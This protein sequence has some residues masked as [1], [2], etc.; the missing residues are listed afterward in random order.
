MS[1]EQYLASL[2]RQNLQ[3]VDYLQRL[4]RYIRRWDVDPPPDDLVR[5][6]P[7][8][9]FPP[10]TIADPA[11]FDYARG[12]EFAWRPDW[13]ADPPPYDFARGRSVGWRLPDWVVD[14]APEDYWRWRD[15]HWRWRSP[16]ERWIPRI[17]IPADPSPI[18]RA[19]FRWM[20]DLDLLDVAGRILGTTPEK[21]AIGDV[22][23]L[24]IGDVIGFEP[25]P[26]VDPAPEDVGR[27]VRVDPRLIPWPG[28]PAPIDLGRW[29]MI[30]NIRLIEAV[31]RI[32][33][34]DVGQVSIEDLQTVKVRDLLLHFGGGVVDPPPDDFR[35]FGEAV[36]ARAGVTHLGPQEITAMSTEELQAT[37]HRVESEMARLDSL[38]QLI[39]K[40]LGESKPRPRKRQ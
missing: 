36:R 29:R 40:R 23:K 38:R 12:R 34:V 13:V 2:A 30:A 10:G 17:P 35:R 37:A 32:R 15:V 21:L 4:R 19:R 7:R 27:W 5:A 25:G 1:I 24:Y 39:S 18:D 11:P 16:W 6:D 33:G 28:D 14:P 26:V 20:L 8:F 31:G 3:L 9:E 22:G